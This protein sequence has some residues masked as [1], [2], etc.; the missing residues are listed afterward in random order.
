[1]RQ[2]L[3]EEDGGTVLITAGKDSMTLSHEELRD[4]TVLMIAYDVIQEKGGTGIS[5]T[6]DG[7]RVIGP[8]EAA[9]AIMAQI[10]TGR[11]A[12]IVFQ[13]EEPSGGD[14][15]GEATEGGS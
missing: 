13:N 4:M 6:W 10:T 8:P 9:S 5:Y 3:I 14:E 1:M 2:L 11:D 15:C 12:D 7:F